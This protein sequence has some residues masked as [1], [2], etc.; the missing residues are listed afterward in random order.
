MGGV[1]QSELEIKPILGPGWADIFDMLVNYR[2][3]GKDGATVNNRNKKA[4]PKGNAKVYAQALLAYFASVKDMRAQMCLAASYGLIEYGDELNA[5]LDCIDEIRVFNGWHKFDGSTYSFIQALTD[6]IDNRKTYY[7]I[8]GTGFPCLVFVDYFEESNPEK[9]LC[10][11]SLSGHES[12]V[13]SDDDLQLISK[14]FTI[15][16]VLIDVFNHENQSQDLSHKTH[17]EYVFL[18]YESKNYSKFIAMLSD[19]AAEFPNKACAEKKA[20]SYL[21][22]C[23]YQGDPVVI[24]GFQA[25]K[26]EF[27][28]FSVALNSA[29][30]KKSVVI[31]GKQDEVDSGLKLPVINMCKQ[32]VCNADTCKSAI[33]AAYNQRKKEG[34]PRKKKVSRKHRGKK[35]KRLGDRYSLF[36]VVNVNEPVRFGLPVSYSS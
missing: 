21:L 31:Y 34:K 26:L 10:V 32:C 12:A 8:K 3:R 28:T 20:F 6:H 18:D 27:K 33:D 13:N 25:V 14:F 9:K 22:K 17:P 11:V 30:R 36:S 19:H 15:M 4:F 1:G 23:N 16:Q 29:Q 7:S 35:K 24:S 2:G 5:L